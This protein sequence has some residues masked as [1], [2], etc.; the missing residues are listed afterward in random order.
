MKYVITENRM[1][2]IVKRYLDREFDASELHFNQP[3]FEDFERGEYGE[4]EDTGEW[5]FGDWSDDNT[6]ARTY[7]YKYFTEEG[8][9]KLNK[10][11]ND[12][13][14]IDVESPYDKELNNMFGDYS[15]WGPGF[16]EWFNEK[17]GS[18]VKGFL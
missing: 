3:E 1:T 6:L 10:N 5:Y 13:P 18:N 16:I 9:Y 15:V 17:T 12:F 8:L 14:L 7:G 2:G 11:E 4:I